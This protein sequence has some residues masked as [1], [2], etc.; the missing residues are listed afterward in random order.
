MLTRQSNTWVVEG[1]GEGSGLMCCEGT[2]GGGGGYSGGM[3][4]I[5]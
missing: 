1:I 4:W 3:R 5:G 2:S